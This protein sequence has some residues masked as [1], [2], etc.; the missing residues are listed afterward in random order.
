MPFLAPL[1]AAGI[2]ALIG[3]GASVAGSLLSGK[4]KTTTQQGTTSS[5]STSTPTFTPEGQQLQRQLLDYQSNLLRDPAAGTGAINAAGVN[6]I[7][8]NYDQLPQQLSQQ[9][10][11]RGFGKSGQLGEGFYQIGNDRLNNLSNFQSEMNKLILGRQAQG[12]ALGQD[13]LNSTRGSTVTTNGT[14]SGSS[15][16]PDTSASNGLLSAGN[17][18]SNLSTLLMLQKVLGS[19]GGGGGGGVMSSG[20]GDFGGS[21]G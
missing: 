12:A 17:G 5:T 14:S 9:L 19:G 15:T 8:N 16:G 2:S 3:G 6:R 20:Y 18:L 21:G 4:P 10:A 1:G 7:N 13:L 11:S